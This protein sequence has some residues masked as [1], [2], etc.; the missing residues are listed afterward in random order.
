MRRNKFNV[1]TAENSIVS[2]IMAELRDVRIQSDRQRFRQNLRRFGQIVGYEISKQLDYKK[3]Q[4]KT[5]LGHSTCAV[6]ARPPVVGGVLRAGV[7]LHEGLLDTFGDADNAFV[8]AY[9]SESS[10]SEIKVNLN[11]VGTASL[12]GRVLIFGDPM[13]ATGGSMIDSLEALL[14]HGT[15]RA[16]HLVGVVASKKGV[17]RVRR[18]FPEAYLWVGAVDSA[19]NHKAY[20]VPGLGDAGDLAFGEKV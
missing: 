4:V 14:R 15:P 3:R 13:W 7:P 16:I 17:E 20:I 8:G 9:R 19:L 10:G 11:Y 2:Q 18:R 6:L 12:T 1:L 5:R